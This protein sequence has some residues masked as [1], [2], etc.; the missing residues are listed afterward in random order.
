MAHIGQATSDPPIVDLAA[1]PLGRV[2][3]PSSWLTIDRRC[4]WCSSASS[5]VR[6]HPSQRSAEA[7]PAGGVVA[8][9][10]RQ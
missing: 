8:G 5:I 9:K 10:R 2:E 1:S 3:T 6:L 7:Q 4:S